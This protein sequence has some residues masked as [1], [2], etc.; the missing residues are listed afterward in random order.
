M[1]ET[2]AAALVY[3]RR[4]IMLAL[5]LIIALFNLL[6]LASDHFPSPYEGDESSSFYSFVRPTSLDISDE[7]IELD[8]LSNER[9]FGKCGGGEHITN[10][11][12][13]AANFE[14]SVVSIER[15]PHDEKLDIVQFSFAAF[16]KSNQ[17]RTVGGDEFRLTVWASTTIMSNGTPAAFKTAC[18]ASDLGNGTYR[19]LLKM[20]TMSLTMKNSTRLELHHWYTC[21][22]GYNSWSCHKTVF[23]NCP[24]NATAAR[25]VAPG[26]VSLASHM[27]L[28]NESTVT[29][30]TK[31]ERS[32]SNVTTCES[33]QQGVQDFTQTG[34]WWKP[35]AS[36]VSQKAYWTPR[37]SAPTS[38]GFAYTSIGDSTM[39]YPTKQIG[40]V[41]DGDNLNWVSYMINATSFLSVSKP[42]DVLLFQG[43][44]HQ[45]F[46]GF[47]ASVTAEIVL[48]M[49]C[50]LATTFRGKVIVLGPN[51]VQ[52]HRYPN[53]NMRHGQM[54][55]VNALLRKRI[56][57]EHGSSL[58]KVCQSML[59]PLDSLRIAARP[60]TGV[61]ETDETAFNRT[62]LFWWKVD[63]GLHN[64]FTEQLDFPGL[65]ATFI[66]KMRQV[67]SV[68]T[69]GSRTVWFTDLHTYLLSR[70]DSY[71]ENIH[72]G[73]SFF[74][75]THYNAKNQLAHM[76]SQG[77]V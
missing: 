73:G 60:L 27:L 49:L 47:R 33:S 61:V 65:E 76:R 14:S 19:A 57:Q 21:F 51:P 58:M 39:P 20:P 38:K 6:L 34:V 23:I 10:I 68:T 50:Q 1:K 53:V 22:E 43:G 44:M 5:A 12:T 16:D 41:H 35:N 32:F 67:N 69:F 72:E 37:C 13:T 75:E 2:A 26:P 52:Q 74:Y 59:F 42:N 56:V 7:V 70:D 40:Y 15:F 46:H 55:L 29:G 66:K 64:N 62:L 8:R 3:S 45:I 36:S 4:N 18:M 77:E 17:P 30:N 24:N 31:P 54:R 25:Q 63:G 28:V 48:L 9:P 11:T 71:R